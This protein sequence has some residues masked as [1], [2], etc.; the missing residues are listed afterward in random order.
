[1][2]NPMRS[3]NA[4]QNTLAF[5][6]LC[7]PLKREPDTRQCTDSIKNGNFG[8]QAFFFELFN[9]LNKPLYN[10]LMLARELVSLNLLRPDIRLRLHNR[11]DRLLA[12]TVDGVE[13]NDYIAGLVDEIPEHGVDAEGGI[14]DEDTSLSRDVQEVGTG[15]PGREEVF[16]ILVAHE[17]VGG[18][19]GE[20]LEMAELVAD[21]EG[22]GAERS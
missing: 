10:L 11:S 17:F 15:N 21:G 20:V 7:E 18:C 3:V 13:V 6:L 1:M 22:V 14:L 2:S 16:F 4:A 19:F 12:R 5:T 8:L 9:R